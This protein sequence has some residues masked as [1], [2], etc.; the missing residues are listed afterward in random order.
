[1]ADGRR[2]RVG[3]AYL[4][5]VDLTLA[6]DRWPFSLEKWYVD[7]LMPDGAVLLLYLGR[8]QLTG[9][10]M[11]RVSAWL[12]RPGHAPERG[13]A[14]ARRIHGR[15]DQLRF[16]AASIDGELLTFRTNGLS[17]DLRFEASF[18][19]VALGAP[20][21]ERDGRQIRWT[22][23]V[24]DARATGLLTWPGGSMSVDGRGYRDRVSFDVAPWRF[25]IAKL[26]W[27]RAAAGPHAATWA[28]AETQDGTVIHRWL[29]GAVVR[30]APWPV[31]L[32]ES[33]SLVDAPV[34]DFEGLRLGIVRPV[35]RRLGGDPWQQ[36]WAARA[37]IDGDEGVAIHEVVRWK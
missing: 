6:P 37:S 29:D 1:V 22:V 28:T 13:S 2:G 12:L 36:K 4:E 30:S 23:E 26:S 20:F 17:G 32:S 7:A 24:P 35:L 15:D 9:L 27:G 3:G 5:D 31:K 8:M 11:A 21:W 34:L 18:P 19:P 16:G 25:P 10:T 33:R 14:V